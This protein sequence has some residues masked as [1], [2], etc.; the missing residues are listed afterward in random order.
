MTEAFPRSLNYAGGNPTS[1]QGKPSQG[2]RWAQLGASDAAEKKIQWR[3]GRRADGLVFSV[4]WPL[5]LPC[6]LKVR[7]I[8]KHNIL[9]SGKRAHLGRCLPCKHEDLSSDPWNPHKKS[10]LQRVSVVPEMWR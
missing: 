8:S 6:V 1:F 10:G 5:Q 4:P 9:G 2:P 7:K 3:K